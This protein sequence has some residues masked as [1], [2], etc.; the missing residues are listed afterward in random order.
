MYIQQL[1]INLM[2]PLHLLL[3]SLCTCNTNIPIRSTRELP[4]TWKSLASQIFGDLLYIKMQLARFLID[5]FDYYMDRN[6]YLQPK[7]CTF[8]SA[9]FT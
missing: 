1:K 9:I 4:Y 7:W 3:V 8:N 6:P 5:G 2:C